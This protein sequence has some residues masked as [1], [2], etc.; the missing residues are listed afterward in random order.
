MFRARKSLEF[1][2]M[3][4]SAAVTGLGMLILAIGAVVWFTRPDVA[5]RGAVSPVTEYADEAGTAAV[6]TVPPVEK[7]VEAIVAP[8]DQATERVTKKSFGI[9]IDRATSPVQPERFAGYH[10]GT[11]FEA[12]PEEATMAVPVT[13]IC[14]G[15][16]RTKRAASGYGGLFV[17]SCAIDAESVTVVYGHLKLSSGRLAAS[18]R[19]VVQHHG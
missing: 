9:Y 13:A 8:L 18:V 1:F 14:S 12:F 4:Q 15:E 17:T 16:V 3:N 7:V 5:E 2:C 19:R 6:E 11:D 10:T